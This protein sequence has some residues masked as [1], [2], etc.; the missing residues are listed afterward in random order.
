MIRYDVI[1]WIVLASAALIAIGMTV[2]NRREPLPGYRS[3]VTV[4]I[5]QKA[6]K[7]QRYALGCIGRKEKMPKN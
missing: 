3:A 7:E 6:N 5:C 2:E 4:D 1:A